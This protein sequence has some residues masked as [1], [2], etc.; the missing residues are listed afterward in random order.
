MIKNYLLVFLLLLLT[1]ETTP[2][3]QGESTIQK[4]MVVTMSRVNEFLA[5]DTTD[6]KEYTD[7]FVCW[8]FG[9]DLIRNAHAQGIDARLV[10]LEFDTPPGH[11]VVAFVTSD[12]GLV[13][14]EPQ[15]D[16]VYLSAW[17]IVRDT[18]NILFAQCPDY[19]FGVGGDLDG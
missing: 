1:V 14:V 3:P 6:A 12:F 15:T 10:G 18:R 19:W 4:P 11:A 7:D 9:C 5:A 13:F 8:N 2:F 17:E 16:K